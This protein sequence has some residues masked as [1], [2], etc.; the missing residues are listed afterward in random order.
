MT[1][2]SRVDDIDYLLYFI[3]KTANMSSRYRKR[4]KKKLL[5]HCLS[6]ES[7]LLIDQSSLCDSR[8]TEV[9]CKNVSAVCRNSV[10]IVLVR[11]AIIIKPTLLS[12]LSATI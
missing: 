4:K 9:L 8:S 2:Y 12:K 1:S 11:G 7:Y 3:D 10:H 5:L 6:Y